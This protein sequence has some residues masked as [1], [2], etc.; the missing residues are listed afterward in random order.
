MAVFTLD[1]DLLARSQYLG[2]P[3]TGNLDTCF[4]WNPCF[5]KRMLRWFPTFQVAN[6]L[7]IKLELVY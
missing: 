7:I 2:G 6:I 1:A 3:A 5:Y 4:S